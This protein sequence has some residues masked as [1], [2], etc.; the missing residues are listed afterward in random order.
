[1]ISS[2]GY[3][4]ISLGFVRVIVMDIHGGGGIARGRVDILLS[5]QRTEQ[6]PELVAADMLPDGRHGSDCCTLNILYRYDSCVH[7]VW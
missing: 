4:S 1:M 5:L 7:I 2:G 6:G 3:R